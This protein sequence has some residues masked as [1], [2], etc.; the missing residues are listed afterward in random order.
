[1]VFF[2]SSIIYY[3]HATF[4][5][6]RNRLVLSGRIMYVRMYTHQFKLYS[7][8]SFEKKIIVMITINSKQN[9]RT[10]KKPIYEHIYDCFINELNSY[11]TSPLYVEKKL[12][13]KFYPN[14]VPIVLEVWPRLDMVIHWKR[15]RFWMMRSRLRGKRKMM[16]V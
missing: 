7:K 10:R 2:C 15:L 6:Q 5:E 1:M 9:S 14:I 12:L 16:V 13:F 4:V 8:N 11:T 3:D